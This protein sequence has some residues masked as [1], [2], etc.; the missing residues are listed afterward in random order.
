MT[1]RAARG[2]WMAPLASAILL[3]VSFPP[4]ALLL[5]PFVALVPFL[6]FVA[7]RPAGVAGRREAARAGLLLGIAY[8]GLLLYWL[9]IA[10]LPD[11]RLAIPA[12][13][14][15]VLVLAGFTTAFATGLHY[16]RER[17]PAVP[18]PIAAALLWT[19]VEWVQG[20]LGDLSFPWLGLGTALA[21]FPRVAGAADLVGARGLTFWVALV[22][23]SLAA[24][25]LE[26]R[27]GRLNARHAT[28]TAAVL[29]L[30]VVYG[31]WRS[32]TL[33]I[34]PAARVAVVQPNIPRELRRDRGAAVDSSLAALRRL[35][36][37]IPAGSV[38]LVAWPEVAIPA[39]LDDPFQDRLRKEIR[40]LGAKVGAPILAGAYAMERPPGAPRPTYYNAAFVVAPDGLTG[41][42]Y[43]KMRLV[44]FVER[45]P[46]VD[47]ARLERI[48]GEML[49]YGG[50]GRGNEATTFAAGDAHYGVLI[51]FESIFASHARILRARGADFL[52][53]ATNDAWYG[54]EGSLGRSTALWQHPAHLVLR[55]IETRTGIAR[56]AN[57]GISLFVDP[58]GR[59]YER[60]T[61]FTHDV[62]AATVYTSDST[63]LFVR[64]GDWLATGATAC[65][66]L[67]L[68]AAR[69]APA[70]GAAPRQPAGSRGGGAGEPS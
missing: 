42:V 61:L 60:T 26:L 52:V 12:Y 56:A 16:V 32:A 62:R 70:M 47:P 14:L 66:A 64:W 10:L 69:R 55:A 25:V 24:A 57:T 20:H 49:Y 17:L 40:T 28:I 15:A 22:N 31:F 23:G 8:F 48:V 53:N 35:T 45:V 30:P 27:D 63:T 2:S 29:A 54:S 46:F 33:T 36:S 4:F 11:S 51:C 38:D 43:R 19:A 59:T 9:A 39:A 18:L 68:L 65:A 1:G 41:E 13:A 67:L 58:L 44:P 3:V 7:G 34:R 6:V 37:A 50:L 21:P 5:P